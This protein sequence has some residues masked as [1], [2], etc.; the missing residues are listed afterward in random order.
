M[1]CLFVEEQPAATAPI[2]PEAGVTG[3][4]KPKGRIPKAKSKAAPA[5]PPSTT[6]TAMPEVPGVAFPQSFQQGTMI[7]H[8]PGTGCGPVAGY[9]GP[10]V[11]LPTFTSSKV[12]PGQF[13]VELGNAPVP[14]AGGGHLQGIQPTAGAGSGPPRISQNRIGG[15]F[16]ATPGLFCA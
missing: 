7:T 1:S 2:H 15:R 11:P 3:F 8:A 13:L 9:A 4:R 12:N 16:A 10:A 6:T 5:G 14:A